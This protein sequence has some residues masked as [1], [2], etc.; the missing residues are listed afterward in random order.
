MPRVCNEDV[1][2]IAGSLIDPSLWTT[3]PKKSD[4]PSRSPDE[5]SEIRGNP[6]R[7]S[8]CVLRSP[9][10]ISLGSAA[11]SDREAAPDFAPLIRATAAGQLGRRESLS[12]VED[13]R[14]E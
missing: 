8:Y 4:Q 7:R 11:N 13:A 12:L 1:T 9:A 3:V 14:D 5:R 2:V 10:A 6:P